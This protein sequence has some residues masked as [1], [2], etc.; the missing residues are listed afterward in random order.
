MIPQHFGA[1]VKEKL[2]W[3]KP[4]VIDPSV[5]Q[6]LILAPI[7]NS[8]RECF[9]VPIRADGSEYLL[10]ENRRKTGFDASLPAEGLLIWHVL[11]NRP[12][13][14]ESHGIEGPAGPRVYPNDVPYPSAANDAFTPYTTP[15]SRSPLG[16]GAPVSI[17][18]VRRLPDGR[19]TF[20]IG[21]EYQ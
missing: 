6:K 13:L 17:T 10:L 8:P 21:Y 16:G 1:W 15:S 12:S 9:K 19:V 4:T 5:K 11:R 7:E 18:N 3:L 14:K 2:G 20:Q